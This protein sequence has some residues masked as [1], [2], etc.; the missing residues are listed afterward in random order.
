MVDKKKKKNTYT[1]ANYYN[2]NILQTNYRSADYCGVSKDFFEREM[3]EKKFQ[4]TTHV[5]DTT[6]ILWMD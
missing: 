1:R 6:I 5:I 4:N 3:I 2:N